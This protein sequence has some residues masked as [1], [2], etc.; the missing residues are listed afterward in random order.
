MKVINMLVI[1]GAALA[2]G[3][4]S[5]AYAQHR[6]GGGASHGAAISR[7]GGFSR[8]TAPRAAAPSSGF[9]R[10]A[11]IAPRGVAGV[12]GGAFIRNGVVAVPR[13]SVVAPV[14]FVRPYY[15]FRPRFSVG[16]GLWAGYPFAYPYAFYDP[17]YYPYGYVDPYAYPS[18]DP[19]AY[20]GYPAPPPSYPAPSPQAQTPNGQSSVTADANQ[21]NMGGLSFDITPN[22]AEIF[23]D[24]NRVGA[25]GQFTPTSQPLG[26]P[27]G[28]HH[29]ELRASGYQTMSI[30]VD[31]I[32]GQVIPYQGQMER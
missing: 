16:F 7:G 24:G 11:V 25:V 10:G 3:L 15:A 19:N 1:S 14:R 26:L 9:A 13:F 12:R 21:A 4:A 20:P 31:I 18:Y 32:A 29:V 27:S 30:D 17:W 22:T 8:A 5:P 2:F 23:V 6:G 28:R